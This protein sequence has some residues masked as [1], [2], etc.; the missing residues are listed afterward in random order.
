MNVKKKAGGKKAQFDP[1]AFLK[2]KCPL[3]DHDMETKKVTSGSTLFGI[4]TGV[5]LAPVLIGLFI[6]HY[7]LK[8]RKQVYVCSNCGRTS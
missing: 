1:K 2:F 8:N 4:A 3:C 5:I 7:A 6:I